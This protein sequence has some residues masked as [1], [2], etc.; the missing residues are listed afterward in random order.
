LQKYDFVIIS[1]LSQKGGVGKTT[2]SINMA[3]LYAAEGA[4]TL[5]IDADPQGSSV[6]WSAV[7]TV[8]PL[9]PVVGMAKGNLHKD[10]PDLRRQ[11][12]VVII[13]GAPRVNE[14]ARSAIIASDVVLIPVQ[15]SPVDIWAS[16]ETV[17]LVNEARIYRESLKA[18]FVM[19]RK[20]ANTAIG[21][22]VRHALFDYGY[23]VLT[24]HISQRVAF[25]ESLAQGLT[26][27]EA[28]PTSPATDEMKQLKEE[29]MAFAEAEVM[30]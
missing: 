19:N 28:Q 7:R 25:A 24:A 20:I 16:Q 30:A 8:E 15:P 4:R 27:F 14:I 11:Y 21:R 1:F 6:S 29:V 5:L 17:Q 9:F 23:P 13:D 22:D 2:L 10:L 3:G 12:D 26:V 18:A